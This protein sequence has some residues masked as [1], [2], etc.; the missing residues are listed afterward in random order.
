MPISELTLADGRTLEI[1]TGGAPDGFP[2]LFH[3]GSPSAV[4]EFAPLDDAARA[5]G[6][7]LIS[8]SR[9]GYGTSTPRA[10]VESPRMADDV[11]ESTELLD[12]LGVGSFVTLGWSGGG[13]RALACAALLAP[14]CLAATS[15]AGPAPYDAVDWKTG[16]AP[17]NVAEYSAAESGREAYD[18]FL[19]AE[20]A[21][22]FA[23]T[24]DQLVAGMGELLTDVDKA[25]LTPPY[26]EWLAAQMRRSGTQGVVGVRE[27]GLAAVSGWGFDVAGIQVPVAIW[28]GRADAMVPP[29]HGEWL[30][31]HVPG[32]R[33]HRF[34]DEG[35]V[36][37]VHRLTE[38]LAELKEMAGVTS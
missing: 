26:A 9:P 34:D 25:A 17:E 28:Q 36:S 35:H 33:V 31:E 24:A 5:A 30:A 8:Y 37:L 3:G 7:R 38:M 6:L 4:V 20:F 18:A 10:G 23:I 12:A 32:A 29:H 21:P 19:V 1:L 2:W 15:L 22:L 14:R 27:D 16:M 11:A 13:P